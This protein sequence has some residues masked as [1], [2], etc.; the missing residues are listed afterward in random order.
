M[1]VLRCELIVQNVGRLHKSGFLR[2]YQLLINNNLSVPY[3]W[4]K[5]LLLYRICVYQ[6][7][8]ND[9]QGQKEMKIDLRN[10]FQ[11]KVGFK[12]ILSLIYH[13]NA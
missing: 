10:K 6:G 4:M 13:A 2:K 5:A 1:H 11:K 3:G 7:R 12:T 8:N 9:E